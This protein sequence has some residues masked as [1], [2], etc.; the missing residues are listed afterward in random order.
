MTRKWVLAF[1]IP[2][3][4]GCVTTERPTFV[5]GAGQAT[6]VRD[7]IDAI[8][9]AKPS[10][11][12]LVGPAT[13]EFRN[14]ARPTF[15]IAIYN[16]STAPFT[17]RVKDISVSQILSDGTEQALKVFTYE[18][19]MAEEHRRQVISAV[20]VGLSAA[21][22]SI[23]ASQAGYYS[24]VGTVSTPRGTST[25]SISGYNPSAA[26]VARNAADAQNNQMIAGVVSQGR[27]NLA[28]LQRSTLKDNTTLPAE[29]Y[30]GQFQFSPPAGDG[31]KRYRI[32]IQIGADSHVIE[33]AQ[34]KLEKG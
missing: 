31:P 29:W 3:L 21:G 9:S 18:E 5:A 14:K 34:A 1:L 20:A 23:S 10:S 7:G 11:V 8:S 6:L 22:N 24:S 15:V 26:A 28:A 25:V 13:P 27:E 30:G 19:L 33:V 17:F 2:A 4:A 32:S 16:R 12:V